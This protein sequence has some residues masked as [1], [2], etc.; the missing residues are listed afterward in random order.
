MTQSHEPDWQ[1]PQNMGNTQ[2]DQQD[3]RLKATESIWKQ[4]VPLMALSIPITGI[5]AIA[6]GSL[7]LFVPISIAAG[8]AVGTAAVWNPF[9]RS[10]TTKTNPV[11]AK[12]VQQLEERIA[13][14]EMILN[15]EE[16]LL[17]SKA[18]REAQ[19]PAEVAIRT[20]PVMLDRE[21]AAT[22]TTAFAGRE[23]S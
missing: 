5:V 6:G 13:S 17:E 21:P 18:R 7:A 10:N 3:I 22:T 19:L 8:A 9:T 2:S 12:Q 11:S 1:H 4:I 14:L 15:Y 20:E 16:K 23:L